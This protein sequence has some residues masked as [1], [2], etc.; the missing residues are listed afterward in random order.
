[1]VTV[2]R[3]ATWPRLGLDVDVIT[4]HS[5][6]EQAAIGELATAE[7]KKLSYRLMHAVARITRGGH[8]LHLCIAATWPWRNELTRAFVPWQPCPAQ[9]LAADAVSCPPL[10][11]GTWST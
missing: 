11:Q 2:S 7:P 8:R 9:P 1:M 10:D 3:E 5:E 4:C 6:K